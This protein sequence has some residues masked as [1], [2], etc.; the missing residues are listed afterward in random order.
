[1]LNSATYMIFYNLLWKGV[2]LAKCNTNKYKGI[3]CLK[4]SGVGMFSRIGGP[5]LMAT[6]IFIDI[7]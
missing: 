1:M 5:G 7:V 4:Y 6:N 3:V 2:V